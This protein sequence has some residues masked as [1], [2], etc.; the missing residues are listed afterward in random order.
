MRLSTTFNRANAIRMNEPLTDEQIFSVAPSVFAIDKHDSRSEKYSYIPTGDILKGLRK[1]G[2]MPFMAVQSKSRI[3]GKEEFTKHM[4]RLRHANMIEANEAHEIILINSHD[5]TSSYQM[6]AGFFRFVCQNGMIAGD[7]VQEIRVPHRGNIE[8]DIINGA[9]QIVENLDN[10]N[11]SIEV[12][13]STQLSLPESRILAESA[14]SLK[15][16]DAQA[17][18]IEATDLL[19]PKRWEDRDKPDLWHTFNRIQENLIKGGQRGYSPSGRRATTRAT[20]S[21][22]GD[23]KLNKALWSLAD[24]MAELKAV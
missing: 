6:L 19:K 7:N 20:K 12:M 18:P 16:E 17:A 3:E 13:K 5:G 14:L 1:E 11:N 23:V 22:D 15:Y 9:Y 4:L 10:V 24:K 21:I 2:F 8:H